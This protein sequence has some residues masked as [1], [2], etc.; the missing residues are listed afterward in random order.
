MAPNF[1]K[2]FGRALHNVKRVF[3]ADDGQPF[4][5]AGSGSLG[6]DMLGANVLEDGD[7]VLV[8]SQGYFGDAWAEW[9]ENNGAKV[10]KVKASEP[11]GFPDLA[12]IKKLDLKRFKV[13]TMT[14]V[15]TSTAV[16]APV[17]ELAKLLRGGNADL[18]IGV[19]GV[20]ATGGEV[21][22]MQEWDIDFAMTGSQKVLSV[23]AGLSITVARPRALEAAAKRK[24]PVR[25]T[26]V[27]WKKWTP[28]MQNYMNEK[29]SY[30]A[31]P[32]V[33]LI[34]ALDVALEQYLADGGAEARFKEHAQVASAFRAA[35]AAWGLRTVCIKPEL[36]ANTLTAIYYGD[37]IDGPALLGGI[38]ANNGAIVAGGLAPIAA[39]YF[40]VGHMGYSVQGGRREH[41]A[42]T[43]NAIEAA[44]TAQ[45]KDIAPGTGL[46]AFESAIQKSAL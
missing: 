40:R 18:I 32:A 27:S 1:V 15:D 24:T 14:N 30:F 46:K 26:Y 29:P 2:A 11:G 5:V 31:T 36:S 7:E 38:K 37:G 35:V 9:A 16:R 10:T 42:H 22:R 19:D 43:I 3:L 28:I 21:L 41:V 12:E 13:A 23:P 44:L 20:A 25:F 33:S 17:Q 39:K 34:F 4:V 6:W 45:G 8:I